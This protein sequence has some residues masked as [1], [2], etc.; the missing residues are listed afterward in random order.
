M[1]I[2]LVLTQARHTPTHFDSFFLSLQKKKLQILPALTLP[3]HNVT[4][5]GLSEGLSWDCNARFLL[6]YMLMGR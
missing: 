1:S 5:T 3:M 2:Q 4:G 6:K